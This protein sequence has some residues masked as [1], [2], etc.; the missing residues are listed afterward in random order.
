[1]SLIAE[2]IPPSSLSGQRLPEDDV[3]SL[4]TGFPLSLIS[5]LHCPYCGSGFDIVSHP[6]SRPSANSLSYGILKC[7]CHHYPVIEGIPIIQHVDG[8][9]SITARI[10]EGN[11]QRAL[12]VAMN[13][14]R[15]KWARRTRWHQLRYCLDCLKLISRT[16]LCFEDAVNLVRQPN[17]FSDYLFHRYANPSFLAAIGPLHLL[18]TLTE[19]STIAPLATT[20]TF[21]E[22]IRVL[23]LA[24]GAGHTSFLM[25]LLFPELAVFSVDHDFVSLY[26]AKRYL[27]PDSTYLCLDAEVPSPFADRLF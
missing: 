5:A 26:L 11:L 23:D 1:M 7:A 25:R 19:D 17:V 8:L 13:V 4:G 3:V 27:A 20:A 6:S 18:G 16:E 24:C 12:L 14:F 10:R 22:P 9:E 21:R 15:V 2:T